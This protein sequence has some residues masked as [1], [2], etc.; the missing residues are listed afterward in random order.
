[1]SYHPAAPLGGVA[2][3]EGQHPMEGARHARADREHDPTLRQVQGGL[4]DQR[5]A[6]Q[7][8][9]HPARRHRRQD[10]HQE[11]P[12]APHAALAQGG[13]GAPAQLPQGR[14]LRLGRGG[15]GH[16]HDHGA[17]DIDEDRSIGR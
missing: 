1:L 13:A 7:P 11:E 4:V 6:L 16:L 17:R 10:G 12:G 9:A 8:R 14:A 15:G 2:L 3:L 5:R